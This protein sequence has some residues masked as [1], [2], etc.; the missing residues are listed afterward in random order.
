MKNL[1]KKIDNMNEKDMFKCIVVIYI[2][3]CV[4][5]SIPA[6]NINLMV[7]YWDEL[8]YY[9]YA[10]SFAMDGVFSVRHAP[11]TLNNVIYSV[12]LAPI[13]LIFKDTQYVIQEVCIVNVILICSSI[14]PIYLLTK[15][16]IKR[17]S[18]QL[19]TVIGAMSL[20]I[21]SISLNILIESLFIPVSFWVFYVIYKFFECD[22]S[23][24]KKR[25]G[26]VLLIGLLLTVLN[27]IKSIGIFVLLAYAIS[28]AWLIVKDLIVN[29]N[30]KL[31]GW[32]LFDAILSGVFFIIAYLVNNFIVGKFLFTVSVESGGAN[33]SAASGIF[34]NG[35][36]HLTNIAEYKYF[37]YAIVLS[38]MI[39]IIAMGFFTVILP[40][41]FSDRYKRET[42]AYMI[43]SEALLCIN[44]FF[45][46]FTIIICETP[47]E[48]APV[49]HYR[50]CEHFA[51]NFF[52]LFAVLCENGFKD[53]LVK[54]GNI[55][56]MLLLALFSIVSVVSIYQFCN[57]GVRWEN[58]ELSKMYLVDLKFDKLAEKINMA[59]SLLFFRIAV[60]IGI[61]A[62]A[63]LF[64]KNKTQKFA[65]CCV[66]FVIGLYNFSTNQLFIGTYTRIIQQ[67]NA[68]R[69]IPDVIAAD[70]YIGKLDGNVL[71]VIDENTSQ[72]S[73]LFDT[74][75]F[76][77]D[78]LTTRE[79]LASVCDENGKVDLEKSRISTSTTGYAKYDDL[80]EVNYVLTDGSVSFD[81]SDAELID[82][83]G[84]SC[85]YLYKMKN[86]KQFT[87]VF[88]DL[89]FFPVNVGT[90]TTNT[91]KN[92]TLVGVGQVTD[93]KIVSTGAGVYIYGP[94]E[95]LTKGSYKL[96]V[97]Y[98][99]NG[100]SV[101]DNIVGTADVCAESG[102]KVMN[103]IELD[104]DKNCE[105]FDMVVDTDYSDAEF[106]ILANGEGLSLEKVV[107][108]KVG[109]E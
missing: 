61:L 45:V 65:V 68:D 98:S 48:I 44:C 18:V 2:L 109:D 82:I 35:L 7:R 71:Q 15:N 20:P 1:V 92:S 25:I 59:P 75:I 73:I 77:T 86:S 5:R 31:F 50:Y 53:K 11:F 69:K 27:S 43:F 96:E 19:I 99:Y 46:A 89:N 47:F 63:I 88:Q 8:I 97:Y 91:Y 41:V 90:V 100:D 37:G 83:D 32:Q 85:V 74:Y 95:T 57:N 62:G 29:K 42:N 78:Y 55:F 94:Y 10:K 22:V 87:P 93:G 28:Y 70:K 26:Y 80:T 17:K 49:H 4:I 81:E 13:I 12:I 21:F 106:R 84:V 36:S 103:S 56:K 54:K 40:I 76:N 104:A 108:T 24:R 101:R 60:A 23:A 16:M 39:T 3:S 51:V 64:L 30:I 79:L 107:I 67:V 102:T 58:F 66:V 72:S 105:T 14:F 33:S 34:A 38:L 52:I 9:G 6:S